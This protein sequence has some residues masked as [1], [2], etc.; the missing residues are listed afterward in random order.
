MERLFIEKKFPYVTG[1]VWTTDALY[2]ETRDQVRKRKAEGCLAVEMEL[3]GVQAVC[4]FHGWSL[5]DYLITGDVLDTPE[6]SHEGL[7]G[8]NHTLTHFDL[9]MEIAKRLL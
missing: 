8:A 7:S 3:A 2:R 5:Y 4:D 9:A 6:Y 1:R